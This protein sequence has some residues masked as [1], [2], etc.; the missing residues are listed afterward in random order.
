[1]TTQAHLR[2]ASPAPSAS[3]AASCGGQDGALLPDP[4]VRLLH[5]YMA[6]EEE[7]ADRGTACAQS[8]H[9]CQARRVQDYTPMPS[10][11]FSKFTFKVACKT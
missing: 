2:A 9:A 10:I 11:L 1:M 6:M 5:G 3:P 4:A 8:A 7:R